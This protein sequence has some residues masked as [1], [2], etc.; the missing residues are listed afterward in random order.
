LKKII[1][2]KIVIVGS[3]GSGKTTFGRRLAETTGIPR[4]EI[5]A[6]FWKPDWVQTTDEEFRPLV[7]SVTSG[8]SWIIDGNYKRV[9]DLTIGRADTVIWLDYSLPLVMYRVILRTIKRFFDQKPLW[10]NNRES[11][12]MVFSKDSIILYTLTHYKIKKRWYNKIIDEQLFANAEFIQI[13]NRKEERRFWKKVE[14][15]PEKSGPTRNAG[16]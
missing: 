16:K 9:Q 12:R 11:L 10:H 4:H 1:G 14:R 3:S 7:D 6:M 13:R 15:H 5:D 8:E 2:K